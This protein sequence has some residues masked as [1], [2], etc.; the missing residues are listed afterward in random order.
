M[1][2]KK[3]N[4]MVMF[5]LI[6]VLLFV[7][8]GA[9]AA[10]NSGAVVFITADQAAYAADQ[11]V[12]IHVTIS[13]PTNRPV[14][15]L[16]WFTPAEDV[17]ESLF[18]VLLDG[19]PVSYMGAIY[20]RPLPTSED[21]LSL[22]AGESL[23]RDV[24][25]SA[26]YDLSASGNYS[27]SYNVD[28]S[29]QQG[30]QVSKNAGSLTSNVLDL[31]IEGRPA[32]LQEFAA[33]EAVSGTTSYVKCTTSQQSLL[34][35]ARNEATNYSSGALSYLNAGTQGLRYT[36]WFGIYNS[37]RYNTAKT[38][39][40]AIYSAMNTASVTFNCGCK[41]KYYAYVYPNQPYIIYLCSIYWQ[42]PMTGTDSKAGT[43]VHE[44]SHFY[45]VAS[46]DDYV[47]GQAG[48]RNLAITDPAKAVDNA[49]NHEY[50]AENNPA[51]P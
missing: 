33:P 1:K 12:M 44:M 8:T 13:N 41:K 47:Y 17:E 15:I 25:L 43:L 45:V 27:I 24:A 2:N 6:F 48:A 23:S 18:S 7:S 11:E 51:Q 14:K 26:Y 20:K 5:A 21:Y 38:H 9:S 37:S 46:T 32:P 35:T 28:L 49:D 39:F 30:L 50:F 34:A 4:V 36:T 19:Q 16:K 29:R 3:F 22:K 42:A 10:S 31:S 40:S